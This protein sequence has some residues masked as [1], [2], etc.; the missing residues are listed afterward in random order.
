M[1][2]R[3]R[4]RQVQRLL[5]RSSEWIDRRRGDRPGRRGRSA[6]TDARLERHLEQCEEC[7]GVARDLERIVE[8]QVAHLRER[9]ADRRI[10]LDIDQGAMAQL[11]REGYDPAFGARPLKRI[12]QREIADPA[13]VLI[14]DGSVGE[15]DTIT[16]HAGAE[17]GEGLRVTAT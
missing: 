17:E 1:S 12:I 6:P 15:G 3:W 16:V 11:A 10:T 13:S 5:G 9:L 7:Q 4:C 2:S 14:L 8:I